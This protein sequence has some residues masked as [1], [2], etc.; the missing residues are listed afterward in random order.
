LAFIERSR[1]V[2]FFLYLPH[3]MPHKP[4]AASADFYQKSGAGLY[5]DVLAELDWSVG[6]ISAKLAELG[7]ERRTLVIFAS[8]NGPWFGGSSGGLRGMKGQCWEGGLRVPAIFSWPGVIPPAQVCDEPAIILDV[9][10]TVLRAAGLSEAVP[11]DRVID[12]QDILALLAS[13]GPSPHTSLFAMQGDQLCAMRAG[14]WKF[15]PEG[16]PPAYRAPA[17]WTDPRAPDGTTIL[18]P[19]EQYTPADYPGLTSGDVST[20]PALYNLLEDPGEQRN[21][22]DQHPDVVRRLQQAFA[23]MKEQ[24]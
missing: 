12:G 15:F 19:R 23:A 14:P 10:P 8:D 21:V 4:L 9:F 7:L 3:A 2:P 17:T 16:T 24:L 13:G 1:D 6:Q 22:A 11:A 20:G 5:G 18:G